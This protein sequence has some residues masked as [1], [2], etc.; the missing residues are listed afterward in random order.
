M[1]RAAE[2]DSK[3]RPDVCPK[4]GGKL[5]FNREP[6]TGQTVEQ[7]EHLR[8]STV[9]RGV[10]M[11]CDYLDVFPKITHPAH[12][13][14]PRKEEAARR[15]TGIQIGGARVK[16]RARTRLHL[17]RIVQL[18]QD[19]QPRTKDEVA[20]VLRLKVHNVYAYLEQLVA[21]GV[22][23]V[24]ARRAGASGRPPK[25]YVPTGRQVAA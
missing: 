4:C 23:S 22:L 17:E 19:Q 3:S 15:K 5:V 16:P 25:E 24:R 11:G 2:H 7:C 10:V 14:P 6:T 18:L 9:K 21:E 8:M 12:T 1:N 13:M 20:A